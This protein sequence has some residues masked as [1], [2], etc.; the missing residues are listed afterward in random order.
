MGD[1]RGGS[2]GEWGTV[3]VDPGVSGR[4]QGEWRRVGAGPGAAYS[5]TPKAEKFGAAFCAR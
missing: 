4:R 3:G 5:L 2:R 1:S